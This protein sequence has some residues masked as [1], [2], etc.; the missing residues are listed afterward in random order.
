MAITWGCDQGR[1]MLKKDATLPQDAEEPPTKKVRAAVPGSTAGS[2]PAP[3]D[4]A[5]KPTPVKIEKAEYDLLQVWG[6]YRSSLRT[7]DV[8]AAVA[9]LE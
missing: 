8:P 9:P 3:G 5:Q 7:Y 6:L 4:T 1:F 2:T